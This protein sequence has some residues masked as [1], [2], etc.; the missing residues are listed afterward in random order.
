M[1]TISAF[2][3]VPPFA[4]GLVRD[5]RVRWALE[6]AGLP[7]RVKLIDP[8]IQKSS[9]YRA[10]QPFGQVPILEENG[11]VLFESGAILLHIAERS[12]VLLPSDPEQRARAVTWVFAALNS[13][14]VRIQQLTEIDLFFKEQEW[15]KARRPQAESAAAVR[16]A[17]LAKWIG[18]R[19]Y[20]EEQFTVGDLMMTTVLRIPRHTDLIERE[21]I[22]A[23]YKA[24]CEARPPFKRALDAQMADFESSGAAPTSVA[25]A[26][27]DGS[28]A[29]TRGA[30][31]P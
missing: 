8:E 12:E 1:I 30:E 7:Y 2:K 31:Q 9:D 27:A 22:L 24:R 18:D 23:A 5:L 11:R 17:D 10:W 16:L 21:P 6:E 15:A 4:Q 26:M 3:W 14:E 29:A 25:R 20:L 13:I 28:P 19:E